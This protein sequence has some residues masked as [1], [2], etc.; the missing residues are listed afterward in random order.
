MIYK[1]PIITTRFAGYSEIIKE[2]EECLAFQPGSKYE[3]AEKIIYLLKNK[4]TRINLSLK[5][6]KR[7]TSEYR[8]NRIA[9]QY[10]RMYREIKKIR[11]H[12]NE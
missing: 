2:G 10:Y 6:Y 4:E 3:L 1:V 11:S 9:E 5:A 8:W 7:A 12:I